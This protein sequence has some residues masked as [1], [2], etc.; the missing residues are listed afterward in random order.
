MGSSQSALSSASTSEQ[1]SPSNNKQQEQESAGNNKKKLNLSGID[2]VN[3]KCRK[4]KAAYSK[5]VSNFYSDKF[6]QGKALNQEDECGDL[7]ETYRRC[8]LKAIK[9]EFFDKG[10]KKPKEGSVLAEEFAD[11]E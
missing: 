3:Y 1:Q 2:L 9:R 7:F 5:C 6:L 4:K 11:D 10:Q 8:Y